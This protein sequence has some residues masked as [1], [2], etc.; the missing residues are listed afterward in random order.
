M[1]RYVEPIEPGFTS[2]SWKIFKE[3]RYSVQSASFQELRQSVR[4]GN[5]YRDMDTLWSTPSC[6]STFWKSLLVQQW[7]IFV[8]VDTTIYQKISASVFLLQQTQVNTQKHARKLRAYFKTFSCKIIVSVFS[9]RGWQHRVFW[10]T[11]F[12][13]IPE[14][15]TECQMTHNYEFQFN[16]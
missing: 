14:L 11:Q 12:W 7:G 3:H 4:A 1:W 2:G 6:N 8:T 16:H 13:S 15:S 9:E 5:S 10:S